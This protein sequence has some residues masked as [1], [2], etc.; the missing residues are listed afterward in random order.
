M[1]RPG[2][3]SPWTL[4]CIRRALFLP[5]LSAHPIT[6]PKRSGRTDGRTRE[7]KPNDLESAILHSASYTD[8]YHG[9]DMIKTS[10]KLGKVLN[11]QGISSFAEKLT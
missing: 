3:M 11:K 9:Y 7:A 8:K 5:F 4:P 1:N 6:V 10:M 2:V